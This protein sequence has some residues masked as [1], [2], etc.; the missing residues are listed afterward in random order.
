MYNFKFLYCN[1]VE[2]LA[3]LFERNKMLSNI[4]ILI[5]FIFMPIGLFG[6]TTIYSEDFEDDN[7]VSGTSGLF[8]STYNAPSDNNWSVVEVGSPGLANSSDY[9][10]VVSGKYL[11]WKDIAGS[12]SNRLDWYSKVISVSASDVSISIDWEMN[13]ASSAPNVNFY[14]YYR[15][16]GG[17]WTIFFTRTN[18]SIYNSGT[19]SITG[20]SCSSSIELKVEGWTGNTSSAYERIDNILVEGTLSTCTPPSTPPSALSVVDYSSYTVDLSW[21]NN[22]GD[23]VL[24]VARKTIDLDVPPVSD[25]SYI[26]NPIFGLG[27][28]IGS[29]NS[30]NFVVYYATGESVSITGL[31]SGLSYSFDVYAADG[32]CFNTTA[33]T[34]TQVLPCPSS[35]DPAFSIPAQ[36]RTCGSDTGTEISN[37]G[38]LSFNIEVSGLTTPLD[39]DANSL[40]QVKIFLKNGN[41][42]D[43]SQYAC[44]LTSPGA[45]ATINL[46]SSGTFASTTDEIQLI[47]RESARL[48]PPTSSAIKPYDIGLYRI[49]TA[50][51]FTSNFDGLANPNGTWSV[52]FSEAAS[53]T[54]DAIELDYIELEFGSSFSE[55]DISNFGANCDGAYE[56]VLGTYVSSNEHADTDDGNQPTKHVSCGDGISGCGCWNASYNEAQ[57]L[58]FTANSTYFSMSV[59]GI[60]ASSGD[61]QVIVVEGNPT[62]CSGHANWTVMSCPESSSESTPN[63]LDGRSHTGNG[64]VE[65]FD[66]SMDNAV[67]GNTYYIII[68]GNASATA[69]YYIHV[70]DGVST[71]LNLPVELVDFSAKALENKVVINWVTASEKNNEKFILQRSHNG[72]NFENIAEIKGQGDSYKTIQ[73]EYT[74]DKP[75]AGISYYRLKQVDFDGTPS[76]TYAVSVEFD[77]DKLLKPSFDL[78]MSDQFLNISLKN[79]LNEASIRLVDITGRTI[80]HENVFPSGSNLKFDMSK[81]P[82]SG[83]LI[84][85]S[86][87]MNG[88]LSTQKIIL[89]N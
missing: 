83:D 55:T 75:L 20:L 19:A 81:Y 51:D 74:D 16:D 68:D 65:N 59:S 64:S 24:V 30:G 21:T 23:S 87:M 57:F 27:D 33:L 46:F 88:E 42:E 14:F 43:L 28:E 86:V 31:T 54:L 44:T 77:A 25:I 34:G 29:G 67:V 45:K 40:R 62:P 22:S 48:N 50:G 18:Q 37:D 56:L 78:W 70:T 53:S 13:G 72:V 17:S 66:L 6:Q 3:H 76:L 84:F 26:A 15:I 89:K 35:S 9:C 11:E 61:I 39:V 36:F 1:Y 52:T 58:K 79:N 41:G 8:G 49:P 63:T 32:T 38:T 2:S 71:E 80:L 12:A 4:L 47:L 73:Y 10:G 60:Q 69:N 5:L 85:V 82:V 7:D